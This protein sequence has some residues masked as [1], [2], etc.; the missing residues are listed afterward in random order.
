M[1]AVEHSYTAQ[2][3]LGH[4]CAVRGSFDDNVSPLS[5]PCVPPTSPHAYM[6]FSASGPQCGHANVG[7][8]VRLCTSDCD[9]G[10]QDS[11]FGDYSQF[12]VNLDYDPYQKSPRLEEVNYPHVAN[13]DSADSVFAEE[14]L[15][16]GQPVTV[17][18][19]CK[20]GTCTC[21]YYIGGIKSQLKPCR[22]GSLIL[23]ESKDFYDKYIDLLWYITDGCPIVDSH[24]EPYE[25][26]NYLSITCPDNVGKMDSII[27]KELDEGIVSQVSVKPHC[28]HALGAVPKGNGGICQ[29]TDCSRPEGLSVNSHCDSLL[30]E[31]CF[32]SVENV[33][34]IL[35]GSDF[36]TVVDIKAAY[37][38]VPIRADHRKYQGFSWIL[39]GIESWFEDNRMCFGLRLGPMYFNYVSTFIFDV[40]TNK[41]FKIVNYLD[42]FIA[43][44]SSYEDCLSAQRELVST[45][46][47]LG[48][49]V[50]F[51][52]LVHPSNTVTYLG[53]E[54]DSANMELRLPKAKLT[55]LRELLNIAVA[56]KRISRKELE[57]LGGLLS[58]CSHVVQGGKIFCRCV[59]LI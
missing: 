36:M 43:I 4:L 58:H 7:E 10:A 37:R 44:S 29:I 31:F 48:F 34:D 28:S 22:F 47:F 46:R 42:E 17:Y 6:V 13:S 55:K 32:K 8:C 12:D 53:I 57:S 14:T 33:V 54:I 11:N 59:F 39:D 16:L 26:K 38:S 50:A 5:P 40:L 20:D 49:H 41:G 2:D 52:K 21:S 51:D 27:R 9:L 35:E 23:Q 3:A 24:V 45:L 19:S 15:P 1:T 30:E 56:R 18:G 25:C